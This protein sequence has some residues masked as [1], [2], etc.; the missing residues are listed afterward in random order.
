MNN[1]SIIEGIE[2]QNIF[3][4][5]YSGKRRS[6]S[7]QRL[8]EQESKFQNKTGFKQNVSVKSVQFSSISLK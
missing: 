2:N 3:W 5:T 6:I 4:A 7:L 1:Y 8:F